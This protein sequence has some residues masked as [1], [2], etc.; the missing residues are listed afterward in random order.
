VG[1]ATISDECDLG[2]LAAPAG[3]A[4]AGAGIGLIVGVGV[5]IVVEARRGEPSRVSVGLR[6]ASPP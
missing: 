5:A 3:Y 4:V 6:I 2:C 1:I